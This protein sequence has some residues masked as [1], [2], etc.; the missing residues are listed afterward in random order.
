MEI[1]G[2]GLEG[3]AIDRLL[4]APLPLAA[5]EFG[6]GLMKRY[7]RLLRPYEGRGGWIG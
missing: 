4:L 3:G 5:G 2:E 6:L 7:E 1:T